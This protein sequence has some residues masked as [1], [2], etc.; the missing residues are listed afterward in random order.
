MKNQKRHKKKGKKIQTTRT[1]WKRQK[2]NKVERSTC[3]FKMEISVLS[4]F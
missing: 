3:A 4:K 2:A 1:L